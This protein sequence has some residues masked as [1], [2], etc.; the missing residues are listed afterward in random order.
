M[1]LHECCESWEKAWKAA[2]SKI[3][4]VDGVEYREIGELLGRS[5]DVN[6]QAI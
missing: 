4:E 3:A 6:I 2:E 5:W 1:E